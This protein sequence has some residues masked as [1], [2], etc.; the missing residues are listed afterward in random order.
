VSP[1]ARIFML[2]FMAAFV[3]VIAIAGEE[4]LSD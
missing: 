2:A 1:T 4:V 3:A